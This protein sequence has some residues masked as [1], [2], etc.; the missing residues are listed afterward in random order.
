M[1][2]LLKKHAEKIKFLLVGGFNTVLDFSLLFIGVA[3]GLDKIVANFI[4]TGVSMVVSFFAN[5]SFTF[6]NNDRATKRQFILFL[7]ITAFGLWVIQPIVI[8][9]VTGAFSTMIANASLLLLIAK[10]IA[11]VASLIWNYL[12]YSRFVFKKEG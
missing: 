7:V 1:E 11:T 5:K 3:L 2:A 8:L 6:K 10:I 9:A 4:S 12:F